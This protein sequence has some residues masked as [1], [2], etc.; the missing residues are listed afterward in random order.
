MRRENNAVSNNGDSSECRCCGI[1]LSLSKEE[2]EKCQ[3]VS[4]STQLSIICEI[5]NG[6]EN[7]AGDHTCVGAI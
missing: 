4:M 1:Q 3:K 6:R 2:V 5:G 7:Q